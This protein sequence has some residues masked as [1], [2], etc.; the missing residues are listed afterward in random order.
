MSSTTPSKDLTILHKHQMNE[1][2]NGRSF[3]TTLCRCLPG[4][5]PLSQPHSLGD[6]GLPFYLCL[7]DV[8]PR[9]LQCQMVRI[10]LLELS[11]V[12]WAPII[13]GRGCGFLSHWEPKLHS[14][15]R[16]SCGTCGGFLFPSPYFSL[17]LACT[18][19]MQQILRKL[20]LLGSEAVSAPKRTEK[21]CE[22]S[23][24]RV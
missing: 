6:R 12:A 19:Q 15:C 2:S 7:P 21:K 8:N 18:Q 9:F 1:Q 16:S 17:G 5:A 11:H 4:P 10:R 14:A 24:Q 20:G 3:L 22:L 13:H 23:A